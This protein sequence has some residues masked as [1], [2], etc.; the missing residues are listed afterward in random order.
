VTVGLVDW[1]MAHIH[2]LCAT[3]QPEKFKCAGEHTFYNTSIAIGP[4]RMFN[5]IYLVLKYCFLMG[6]LVAIPLHFIKLRFRKQLKYFNPVLVS[7]GMGSWAPYNLSYY[8]PGFYVSIA[9]MYMIRKRYLAWWEKYNY[10]LHS[11]LTSGVAFGALL[12]FFILQYNGIKLM[13]WGHSVS[14]TGIDGG[15]G[16]QTLLPLP[17]VG[18]FG[19]PKG[20]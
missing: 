4:R 9:F 5:D 2:D 6:F 1:Q 17:E 15:I 8:T 18:Y 12:V 10:I 3:N 16:R 13:W 7:A 19:P 14:S 20:H 11:G